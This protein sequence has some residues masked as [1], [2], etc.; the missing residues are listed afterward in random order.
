[1]TASHASARRLGGRRLR[2]RGEDRTGHGPGV[3]RSAMSGRLFPLGLVRH[4]VA[5]R[6][7]RTCTRSRPRG[8]RPRAAHLVSRSRN[9]SPV[10]RHP[11]NYLQARLQYL[12]SPRSLL[13]KSRHLHRAPSPRR[14]GRLLSVRR[15][16]HR[17]IWRR[18]SRMWD[19][20]RQRG[21]PGRALLAL[22]C[23]PRDRGVMFRRPG[24]GIRLEAHVARGLL[25]RRLVMLRLSRQL[26]QTFPQGPATLRP[27][28]RR[29]PRRPRNSRPPRPRD[30]RLRNPSGPQC[31]LFSLPERSIQ[32]SA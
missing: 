10:S 3:L 15:R 29:L 19:G 28:H 13:F 4:H 25:P 23:R 9:S 24:E 20:H 12:G 7:P 31:R 26:A 17:G 30:P 27:L 14:G 18:R 6:T 16:G 22:K 11:S 2:A 21:R 1:M 32:R 5:R 8:S